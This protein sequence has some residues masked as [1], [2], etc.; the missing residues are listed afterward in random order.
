MI[1]LVLSRDQRMPGGFASVSDDFREDA[2]LPGGRTSRTDDLFRNNVREYPADARIPANTPPGRYFICAR[3]DAGDR[4][5]ESNERNNIDC[6]SIEIAPPPPPAIGIGQREGR[7][8]P[9]PPA[10]GIGHG[11]RR[12]PPPPPAIGIG[13]GNRGPGVPHY[14]TGARPDL[15]VSEFSIAPA[16]PTE[17]Q[18]VF[19]RIAVYNEGNQDAGPFLVQ[20]WPGENYREPAKTW[21]VDGMRARGGRTLTFRYDGYPSWYAQIRTKVVV[22]PSGAVV[23]GEERNNTETRTIRVNRP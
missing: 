15:V 14:E 21:R 5:A 9:P 8:I 4:V 22:D 16:F 17:G 18:P 7:S 2:L 1:D 11:G 13:N 19:V 20:W 10:I 23:E 6:F 12:N 3:V